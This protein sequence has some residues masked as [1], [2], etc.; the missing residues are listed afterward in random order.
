MLLAFQIESLAHGVNKNFM[1]TWN[2][3]TLTC[4][5]LIWV[6]EALAL[7]DLYDY[8]ELYEITKALNGRPNAPKHSN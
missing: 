3:Q 8:L 7:F 1:K 5:V 4:N 6:H 2:S